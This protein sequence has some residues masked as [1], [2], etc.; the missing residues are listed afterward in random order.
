MQSKIFR[1]ITAL[2]TFGLFSGL[3]V[4]VWSVLQTE[5]SMTPFSI[6]QVEQPGADRSVMSTSIAIT[7]VVGT[8]ASSVRDSSKMAASLLSKTELSQ[9]DTFLVSP[10]TAAVTIE[11]NVDEANDSTVTQASESNLN[12][13]RTVLQPTATP[14]PLLAMADALDF[15]TPLESGWSVLS[16]GNQIHDLTISETT[17]WAATS[18]GVVAWNRGNNS[19][20][21]F[22]TFDG[23]QTNRTTTVVNCPFPGL[24]LIFGTSEG[25]QRFDEQR[26]SWTLL[27]RS[28]TGMHHDDIATLTCNDEYGFLIVGY[29]QHGLDIFEEESGEWRFMDRRHGLQHNRVEQ[30]SV[31][32]DL[33]EI[34]VSSGFGISVL[35]QDGALFYDTNNSPLD[36]TQ[37][38][39]MLTDEQGKVWLGANDKVYAID[40]ADWTIFSP[41]YVLASQFPA[42]EIT[43]LAFDNAGMLWIGSS[44][45]ELCR[46]DLNAVTCDPFFTADEIGLQDRITALKIDQLNQVYVA[47]AKDGIRLYDT[48]GW[49]TFYLTD[50]LPGNRVRALIQDARGYLWL[51]TDAGL[52]QRIPHSTVRS[53]QE[54]LLFTNDNTA[55]NVNTIT[56]LADDPQT[57][58]WVGGQNAGY[59]DGETWT[60]FTV[61]D[62]LIDRHVQAIVVDGLQRTW[63]GTAA[64]LSIWNGERFSNLT[65]AD[66]LPSDNITALLADG[67]SVWIG[68]DAGLL[69]FVQNQLQIFTQANSQL[70]S[71]QV[72]ALAQTPIGQLWIGTDAGLAYF[73]EGVMTVESL[74]DGQSIRAIVAG[75]DD[76]IWLA[77]EQGD[78]FQFNGLRWLPVPNQMAPSAEI[79]TLFVDRDQTLWIGG[80]SGLVRYIP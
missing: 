6:A 43:G 74:F 42:G 55:Y 65:T 32:G 50:E 15:Q 52:Q 24:G 30:V 27:N 67:E 13:L 37:I 58:L 41:S 5:P 7:S 40:G 48:F 76:A 34:W 35:T 46:F 1:L 33:E 22:T 38:Q 47:T 75:T 51:L 28:N 56:T 25:L 16:N 72:T 62:G 59:F 64:G 21:K 78:L 45:G 69:Y 2:L 17:I 29:Q 70:P 26:N 14:T 20:T 36:T 77:T 31:V 71:N 68:T 19:A 57:G 53:A 60:S 11:A 4:L 9:R 61:A 10:T 3:I 12:P 49:R 18:G 63:F 23:L 8:P 73:F 44:E 54:S 66:G 39:V 80:D 79:T